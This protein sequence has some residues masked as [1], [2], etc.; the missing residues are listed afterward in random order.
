MYKNLLL[1]ALC[2]SLANRLQA[3]TVQCTN[4][5]SIQVKMW[6]DSTIRQVEITVDGN[7][8]GVIETKASCPKQIRITDANNGRVINVFNYV[9]GS[10]LG[11]NIYVGVDSSGLYA[12]S[13]VPQL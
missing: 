5:T 6:V 9:V 4:A 13:D 12:Q 7:S 2:L 1:A 11:K 8:R 10:C 3:Y